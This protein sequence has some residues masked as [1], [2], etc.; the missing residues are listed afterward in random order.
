MH[1]E[2]IRGRF[3]PR[4]EHSIDRPISPSVIEDYFSAVGYNN[5]SI[6]LEARPLLTGGPEDLTLKIMIVSPRKRGVFLALSWGL[7]AP[8][9]FT[10]YLEVEHLCIVVGTSHH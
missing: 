2:L 7:A 10:V 8:Q 4:R 6:W 9:Y 1:D 3:N 5:P